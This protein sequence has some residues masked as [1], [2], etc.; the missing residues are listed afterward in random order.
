MIYEEVKVQIKNSKTAT[1][2]L[3][4]Q[5]E[6][7]K[8][9]TD[10]DKPMVLICPGGGYSHVSPRE[11]EAIAFRMLANNCHAAVLV[12]DVDEETVFPQH[13]LELAYSVAYIRNNAKKYHIAKDKIIVAGFSA[14]AHLAASLGCFWEKDFLQKE[15]SPLTKKDYEPNGL[16][17]GYP[18]ITSGEH[19]HRGSFE[20]LLQAKVND[21]EMLDFVSLEKQVSESVPPVFMW[22]TFE[23]QAVPLENSLLFAEALREA[24]VNFE[25]HVFPHG[26]HGYALGTM[27]TACDNKKE[28][29]PQ[30]PQWIGLCQKWIEINFN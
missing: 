18:V 26:G 8:F 5:T 23:D 13:L 25:Y 7:S 10:V 9:Q 4:I 20:K 30:I 21:R 16:I 11:G 6:F 14:G 15:M 22:H 29:D 19:A 27:E 17:L 3:Y 24:K 2:S 12:Y 1:L 28:I